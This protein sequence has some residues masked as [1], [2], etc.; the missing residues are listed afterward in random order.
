M[1]NFILFLCKF[2]KEGDILDMMAVIYASLIIKGLKT[3][4]Q[5]PEK[6]K[7]QVQDILDAC[8]VE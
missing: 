1:I 2:I 5:V 7:K 4:D 8:E 3:I 6:L